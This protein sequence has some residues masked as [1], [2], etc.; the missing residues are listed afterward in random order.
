MNL[1]QITR[2]GSLLYFILGF[3]LVMY[4]ELPMIAVAIFGVIFAYT[5]TSLYMKDGRV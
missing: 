2:Q 1:R 4:L 5:Y 3:I